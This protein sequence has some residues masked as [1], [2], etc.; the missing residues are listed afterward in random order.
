M[1]TKMHSKWSIILRA[2]ISIAL[3]VWLALTIDWQQMLKLLLQANLGW[4]AVAVLGII[5]SMLISVSKWHLLLLA[6]HIELKW[7]ELWHAYWAGLFFNNFLPSSIG[8]DALRIIWVS[9]SSR[10]TAGATASVVVERILATIAIVIVGLCGAYW[11]G[12][13]DTRALL[14]FSG[15]LALCVILLGFILYGKLPAAFIN[16]P[17]RLGQFWQG[18]IRH[19]SRIQRSKANM[20]MVLGLSIAFQVSVV[21][22]NYAIFQALGINSLSWWDLLFVIPITSVAAMLPIGINGYGVREGAYVALLSTYQ[23]ARGTAFASSIV[24]AFLVSLCSLYGGWTLMLYRA[25]GAD[26]NVRT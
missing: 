9:K 12:K 10:D 15:L 5:L 11:T 4:L 26:I 17:G 1:K 8:G 23:V 2:L 20:S 18:I 25:R 16:K 24:F 13:L 14:L 6:Q 3:L 7:R 21:G 22:V 19:G